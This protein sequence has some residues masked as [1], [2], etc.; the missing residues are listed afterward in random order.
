MKYLTALLPLLI[1]SAISSTALA[2]DA[3]QTNTYKI[4]WDFWATDYSTH[5]TEH[6][7]TNL[8]IPLAVSLPTQLVKSGWSCVRQP[9]NEIWVDPYGAGGFFCSN[10]KKWHIAVVFCKP[11]GND[12]DSAWASLDWGSEK[13]GKHIT[14]YSE[15]RATQE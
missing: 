12:H 5:K 1:V 13:D 11:T 15:C 3:S 2:T 14:L 8:A 6:F 7:D 9:V 10:G 4:K